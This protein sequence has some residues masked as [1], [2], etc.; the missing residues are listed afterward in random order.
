MSNT[1][2]AKE[3]LYNFMTI[4]ASIPNGLASDILNKYATD[5]VCEDILKE[6]NEIKRQQD[7][8]FSGTSSKLLTEATNAT[9]ENFSNNFGVQVLKTILNEITEIELDEFISRY[10][11]NYYDVNEYN[12]QEYLIDEVTLSKW[13]F[14][15]RIED[16]YYQMDSLQK[17]TYRR[18]EL[19]FYG[20]N[21]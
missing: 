13:Q 19:E 5:D 21:Y 14:N 1:F 11:S 15:N 2:G 8:S 18:Y 7:S 20:G 10:K 3:I 6:I 12:K 17:E 4:G 9:S 16:G